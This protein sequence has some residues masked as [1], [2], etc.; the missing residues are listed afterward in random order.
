MK[1]FFA[2]GLIIAG[3]TVLPSAAQTGT[4]ASGSTV[5]GA[6][7]TTHNNMSRQTER[8]D[9]NFDLG[10]LGL[11]GLAGLIPRKQR[12]VHADHVIEDRTGTNR[13]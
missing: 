7:D 2:T 3:L 12:V 13:H 9:N 8:D 10:W 6:G 11:I 4:G 1:R 5:A